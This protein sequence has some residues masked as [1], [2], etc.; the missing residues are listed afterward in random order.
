MLLLLLMLLRLLLHLI[1][2]L[3]LGPP[4]WLDDRVYVWLVRLELLKAETW[5]SCR[6]AL[7]SWVLGQV[8]DRE[9]QWGR[10]LSFLAATVV[11]AGLWEQKVVFAGLWSVIKGKIP[12]CASNLRMQRDTR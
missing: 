7:H 6:L 12:S 5:P 2:L 3:S 1:L 11:E 8:G 10:K 9:G 4:L